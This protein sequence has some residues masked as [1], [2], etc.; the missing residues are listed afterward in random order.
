MTSFAFALVLIAACTHAA[1]NFLAKRARGG[2]TF[3]WLVA[4]LSAVLYAPFAIGIIIFQQLQLG[5]IDLVFISGSAVLHLTYFL[6]LQRGYHSG[7]LSLVYPLARGTGP[8]LST[9]AAILF[10]GERPTPLAI[11]GALFIG[12]GVLLLTSVPRDP[13]HIQARWAML[14]GLL[15]GMLIAVYTLWDKHAVSILLIPPLVLDYGANFGRMVL[16]APL[17][18]HR[19]KQVRVEWHAHRWEVLGVAVLSPLAYILVLTALISTPVSYV[20]PAREISILIGATM[21]ARL[22]AEG[23]VSRRLTAASAMVIGAIALA[24]G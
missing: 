12:A 16:L 20:A 7:D 10:F 19:R 1:W 8:M 4:T 17:A 3:V 24:I 2:A 5:W 9:I 21:G 15:T 11:V 14:Y 18:L 6:L 23:H 13:Q 22:L